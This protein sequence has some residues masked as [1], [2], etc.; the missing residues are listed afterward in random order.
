M[1]GGHDPMVSRRL[2][3]AK[4]WL[5]GEELGVRAC[6]GDTGLLVPELVFASMLVWDT[7]DTGGG[8]VTTWIGWI[9][10]SPARLVSGLG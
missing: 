5:V 6:E 4:P 1:A 9:P 10:G 2:S 3:D 7:A 8:E